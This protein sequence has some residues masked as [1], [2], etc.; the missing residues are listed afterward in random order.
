M[1][2]RDSG[3]RRDRRGPA[4]NRCRATARRARRQRGETDAW[5]HAGRVPDENAR[6]ENVSDDPFAGDAEERENHGTFGTEPRHQHALCF[7]PEGEPVHLSNLSVIV[8]ARFA[9]KPV[10]V[11]DAMAAHLYRSFDLAHTL[12][13]KGAYRNRNDLVFKPGLN[14]FQPKRRGIAAS[15]HQRPAAGSCAQ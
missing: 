13:A 3:M 5:H 12:A 7:R 9:N 2:R 14:K 1:P 4:P 6:E 10:G 11:L 8:R 15:F